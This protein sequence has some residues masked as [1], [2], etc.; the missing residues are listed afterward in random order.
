MQLVEQKDMLTYSGVR[1]FMG[2]SSKMQTAFLH[3]YEPEPSPLFP[4]FKENLGFVGIWDC[5]YADLNG[6]IANIGKYKILVD[7]NT[8]DYPVF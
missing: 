5:K 6:K 7:E 2:M 1:R 8:Y 3:K 4:K